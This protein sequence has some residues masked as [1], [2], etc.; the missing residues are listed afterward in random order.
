MRRIDRRIEVKVSGAYLDKDNRNAGVQYEANVTELRIEFDEGWEHYAKTVTFW[1]AMMANPVKRTLTTNLLEDATKS[2]RVYIVPIP[3]EALTEAGDM[4]F[5]ID[6]YED[7]KRKRS[8]SAELWVSEAPFAEEADEPSDPTPTQAEQLQK[9]IDNIIGTIAEAKT[10][11]NEAQAA[12]QQA[13]TDAGIAA[14]ALKEI[15]QYDSDAREQAERAAVY[16]EEADEYKMSAADDASYAKDMRDQ[17]QAAATAAEKSNTD[18][19]E[20]AQ[21]AE[22]F[23]EQA[24]GFMDN[25]EAAKAAAESAKTAAVNAKTAAETAKKDAETAKASAASSAS[26]ANISAGNAKTSETKAKTSETNAASSASKAAAAQTAAE[27]AAAQAKE[28]AVGGLASESYVN[29]KAATRV[30][31]TGDSM[32]GQ[33]MFETPT[34]FSAFAKRRTING[35]DYLMRVGIGNDGEDGSGTFSL[36]LFTLGA[37]GVETRAA[38]LD[39]DKAGLTWITPEGIRKTIAHSGNIGVLTATLEG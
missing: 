23:M 7:G 12:A 33:L 21:Q 27:A 25:A 22:E 4:T 38:Q 30:L 35:T 28:I 34:L 26:A 18:A 29:E 13:N 32:T 17:A 20:Y 2:T 14:G 31:K 8:L 15:E 9:Q 24:S 36:R 16:A 1:N 10:A 19:A 3:G 39:M 6:G 37:N 11:R 5:V